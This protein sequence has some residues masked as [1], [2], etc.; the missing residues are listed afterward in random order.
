MATETTFRLAFWALLAAL[1][2]VRAYFG[3]RVRQAGERLT[4]DRRAIER[5][6]RWLFAAR[7]ASFFGLL[8]VLGIYAVSPSWLDALAL[9]FP[10]WLRWAGFALGAASIAGLAWV[11]ATLGRQFSAQLQIRKEHELITT[12]PYARVRHPLYTAIIGIGVAFALVTANWLF[13][14]MAVWVAVGLAARIPKEERMMIDEFGE[15]YREY[16]RHTGR[17]LPSFRAS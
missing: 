7:L 14:I 15:R 9:P 3:A 6:G 8:A 1:L 11:Q 16:M 4:P 5:E 12:G 10:D 13:V 17:L 2:A